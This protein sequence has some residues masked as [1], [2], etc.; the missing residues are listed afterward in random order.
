[1]PRGVVTDHTLR[2]N[3]IEASYRLSMQHW[4]LCHMQQPQQ[5]V[6]VLVLLSGAGGAPLVHEPMMRAAD[7]H[8]SE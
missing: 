1:M 4:D 6:C 3:E 8:P 5:S 2:S 7:A